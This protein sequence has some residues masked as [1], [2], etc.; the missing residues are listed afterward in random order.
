LAVWHSVAHRLAAHRSYKF[1]FFAC[2][3]GTFLKKI[4]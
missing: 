4:I 1:Y 2:L 3:I